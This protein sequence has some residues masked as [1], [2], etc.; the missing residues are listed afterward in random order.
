MKRFLLPSLLLVLSGCARAQLVSPPKT[1]IPHRKLPVTTSYVGNTLNPGP[2]GG[3]FFQAGR[4]FMASYFDDCAV[5][6]DGFVFVSSAYEEGLN[7]SGVY[8]NGDWATD[9]PFLFNPVYSVAVSDKHAVYARGNGVVTVFDRT[10]GYAINGHVNGEGAGHDY[11]VDEGAGVTA[12][13]GLAIDEG[14]GRFYLSDAKGNIRVFNLADGKPLTMPAG[15]FNT[16]RPTRLE[17]DKRGNVWAIET[18]MLD[19][20]KVADAKPFGSAGVAG[21]EA[22]K[23]NGGDKSSFVAGEGGG[24]IGLDLG[25]PKTLAALQFVNAGEGFAGATIQASNDQKTWTDWRAIKSE[26]GGWPDKWFTVNDAKPYR[27]VRVLAAPDKKLAIS[28][29]YAYAVSNEPGR[30]VCFSPDGRK[31]P[32]AIS[33]VEQPSGIAYDGAHD[34]LLVSHYG[35]DQQVLA[36]N[37]LDGTPQL[38]ASFGQ[39]GRFGERG[40]IFA[41]SAAQK[42]QFGPLRFDT[43]RDIGTDGAGN[44]YV[45]MVGQSGVSGSRIESYTP[46]GKLRWQLQGVTTFDTA[47]PLPQDETQVLTENYRFSMNY[48][49]LAGNEWKIAATTIDGQK[50]P[51]DPRLTGLAMR[52]QGVCTIGGRQFFLESDAGQSSYGVYRNDPATDG[53]IWKPVAAFRYLSGNALGPPNQPIEGGHWIWN[54]LNGDG[55]MDANEYDSEPSLWLMASNFDDAGNFWLFD[56]GAQK[57]R[58]LAPSKLDAHGNPHWGWNSPRNHEWKVPAPFDTP[59]A[60]SKAYGGFGSIKRLVYD[61]ASNTLYCFGFNN[62][63]P[64]TLGQNAPSG[65]LLVR[66]KVNGNSLDKIDELALP[67]GDKG[68]SGEPDDQPYLVTLGGDYLFVGYFKHMVNRV[69]RKSDLSYVGTTIV[70]EQGTAP[71][72]DG[73]NELR[74]LPRKNG[75]YLIFQTNYTNNGVVMLRWKPS[76]TD[77]P[78]PPEEFKAT[79]AV[80]GWKPSAGAIGYKIERMEHTPN[81]WGEWSVAAQ[82]KATS[83]TDAKAQ[84]GHSYAYRLR[85][86]NQAAAASDYTRTAWV[87]GD[88][89]P[90]K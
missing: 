58:M 14:R 9:S 6:P 57:I 67:Y 22:D 15:N 25:A 41:G 87:D 1:G 37:H 73:P 47:L 4:R 12:Y 5:S 77:A 84:A 83:W 55:K 36:Y 61:R 27:Y 74:V 66:Y 71:I 17:V 62:D 46:A 2:L 53:N 38:D 24:F 26:L 32:A 88:Q 42:G 35:A 29:L 63:Y 40:G 45:A 43:V 52:I 44:L 80:L 81:G 21:N 59:N 10:P 54:D 65:R 76:V 30:I 18:A 23:L 51:H 90:A 50:Y 49:K 86:F 19:P 56:E 28:G 69:Y 82:T 68:I 13:K 60:S 48:S 75:E 72:Y 3:N 11:H 89:N 64:N 20:Q 7:S 31:L 70:G 33:D 16:K 85:A 39:G 34:R 78:E 8:H 79:G